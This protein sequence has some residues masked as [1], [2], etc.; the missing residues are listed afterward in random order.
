LPRL[1]PAKLNRAFAVVEEG[2][3]RGAYAGAV[4]AVAGADGLLSVQAFGHAALEPEIVAMQPDTLFDLASL[5]KVVA[6]TPAL[7]RLLEEGAFVLETPVCQIIP[8]FADKRVTMRHLMTHTSGLPAWQALYLDHRGWEAYTAAIAATPLVRDPGTQVEYSDLGFMLLGAV[9]QR[10]TGLTLP[11][12]CKRYVFEPLGMSA[13]GWLPQ[14]PLQR[15]AATETGNATEYGMCKERAAAFDRW[16]QHV[17][18]G[19]ANDGNCWYGLD[20]VSS[21]AGLFGTA[22]DLA[23]Y[24]AAWLQ[25]GGPMLGRHTVAVATR[26]YTP[27]MAEEF[28]ATLE[29]DL[30][31][32]LKAQALAAHRA[33]KLGGY[34]R[35]D[36]RVTPGGDIFFLEAN[37]LPGMTPMSLLPQ[38]A[39]ATG[40]DFEALCE[41]IIDISLKKYR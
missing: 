36:F 7:L 25:V 3:R 8:A 17:L 5:T 1:D 12:Y 37:T 22:A 34:S 24:A 32:A 26:G 19:E 39:K 11:E 30:E 41:K 18:W 14:T 40:M 20:G 21:H 35:V 2:V 6:A 16:R 13:T 31:A 9:I 27:G 10:L 23:R 28:P 38:E 15:V 33:L 29:P 4:A